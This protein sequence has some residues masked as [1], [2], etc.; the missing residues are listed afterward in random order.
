[1]YIFF[2]FFF[3]F[4]RYN[5]IPKSK[6]FFGGHFKKSKFSFFNQV[7]SSYLVLSHC[8]LMNFILVLTIQTEYSIYSCF[9]TKSFRH[10]D[11]SAQ[12]TTDHFC[13]SMPAWV[14]GKNHYTGE[15]LPSFWGA[16]WLGHFPSILV[17]EGRCC[18]I[19]VE[20]EKQFCDHLKE[21][22]SQT[23]CQWISQVSEWAGSQSAG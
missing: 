1:M 5:E 12:D 9:G 8:S 16:C 22:V 23:D 11:N 4:Y 19:P 2:F 7:S 13:P 10:L 18:E 21:N 20:N 14:K 6:T 17:V 15:P 3:F